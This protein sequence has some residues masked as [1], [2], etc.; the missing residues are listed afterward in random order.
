MDMVYKQDYER[1]RNAITRSDE[2]TRN[3]K[4]ITPYNNIPEECR[5]YL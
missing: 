1:C 4:Y 5:K 2:K 3:S